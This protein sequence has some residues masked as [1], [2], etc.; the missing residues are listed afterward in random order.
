MKRPWT[1]AQAAE[2]TCQPQFPSRALFARLQGQ[3]G[4]LRDE[5]T[6][7]TQQIHLMNVTLQQSASQVRNQI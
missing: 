1:T 7:L 6:I 3:L 2:S 5:N 4:E